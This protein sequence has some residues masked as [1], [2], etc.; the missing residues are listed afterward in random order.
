ME[1]PK[2]CYQFKDHKCILR[3]DINGDRPMDQKNI[4]CERAIRH[5]CILKE[6]GGFLRKAYWAVMSTTVYEM[7][8]D[9]AGPYMGGRRW[10]ETDL[11]GLVWL[12]NDKEDALNFVRNF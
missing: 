11:T 3:K 12:F 7:A 4:S 9:Y 5:G 8:G 2:G 6:K 1:L 10:A